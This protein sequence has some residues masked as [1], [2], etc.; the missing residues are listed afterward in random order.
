MI[1]RGD[2]RVGSPRDGDHRVAAP[3]RS[4]DTGRPARSFVGVTRTSPGSS[5]MS[6]V[7][8]TILLVDDERDLV[9]AVEFALHQEGWQ[10]KTADAGTPALALARR[11]PKPDLIL[12]DLMLPDISG[13]DV[14][15]QLKSAEDTADIPIIMLTAKGEEID[16]VVGFEV[17]ADD[18]VT[19]PFSMRELLLRI[20]AVLRRREPPQQSAGDLEFGRLRIDTAG[21]RVWVEDALVSLTAL[22]FRLLT[23]FFTRRGRVLSRDVL[24]TDVWGHSAGLPTRTVDTHIQRLRKKLGAA[25]DYIETL[26]GVGYRFR[27][28]A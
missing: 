19:K 25:G 7:A 18:Y 3:S 4:R 22:E 20:K 23:T 21:H 12:L 13:T 14:C 10:T 16:R 26:R 9:D 27:T 6:R 2:G 5:G 8:A 24:L 28:N 1:H 11:E 17:G 15:R